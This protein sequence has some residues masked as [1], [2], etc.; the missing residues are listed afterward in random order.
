[1][2]RSFASFSGFRYYIFIVIFLLSTGCQSVKPWERDVLSRERMTFQS[3]DMDLK[4]DDHFYFSKE[5]IA[6]GRGFAGGG[7]GCN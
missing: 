4:L 5:G 3:N 7:C 2:I 6:G 1:M